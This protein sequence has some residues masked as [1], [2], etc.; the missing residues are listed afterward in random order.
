M[1]DLVRKHRKLRAAAAP[2]PYAGFR[3]AV[4]LLALIAFTFQSYLVQ[5]HIHGLPTTASAAAD[6]GTHATSFQQ[7]DK[8]PADGN[9]AKCLLCQEFLHAGA[10]VMPAAFVALPPMI[11]VTLVKLATVPRVAAKS[12][13]HIWI[14]RAPPHA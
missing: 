11:A 3:L 12:P 14:G 9:E 5:T 10:Y 6:G 4:T 7:G 1:T 2:R 13:S 8:S